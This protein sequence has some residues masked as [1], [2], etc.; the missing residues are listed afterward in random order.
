MTEWW[1]RLETITQVFYCLAAFF[2]VFLAWQLIAALIGLAG[3]E[4][5]FGADTDMDADV[6][7]DA[8]GTYDEFESGAESDALDSLDAFRLVSVRSVV[9]FGTLFTW[10]MAL[11]LD[12]G[13]S[14]ARCMAYA[15]GWGVAG[16]FG[17][18]LIFWGMKKM[19]HT[20]TKNLATCAGT[21][22][23]VYV[24]IPEGGTGEV[25]VTVS[26]VISYVKARALG[27]KALKAGTPI[28][29]ERCVGQTMVLVKPIE[30]EQPCKTGGKE[31]GA[32]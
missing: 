27:G 2:S 28:H 15:T 14:L 26:G 9:A 5:D 29:V 12:Q 7:V 31:G 10:A 17:V 16:M 22:G 21:D 8:D 30:E 1:E 18:A 20:G 24:D 4:A 32:K 13:N 3:D 25:R 19:T 23:T 11:F 6:D